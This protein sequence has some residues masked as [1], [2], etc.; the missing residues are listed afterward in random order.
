MNHTIITFRGRISEDKL[1]TA[2]REINERRFKGLF[3]VEKMSDVWWEI[4]YPDSYDFT[5]VVEKDTQRKVNIRRS[6]GEFGA[7]MEF[8]FQNE[9]GASL[10]GRCGDQCCEERRDPNPAKALDFR[11][12]WDLVHNFLDPKIDP[13]EVFDRIAV[14][15]ALYVAKWPEPLQQFAGEY[16]K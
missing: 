6:L 8:V 13:Q 15:F 5:L 2:L 10:K 1:D 4:K 16:P 14:R 12:W 11:A 9:L 3:T 7:W